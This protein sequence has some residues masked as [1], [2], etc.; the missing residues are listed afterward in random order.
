[1]TPS[2]QQPRDA[3]AD[4]LVRRLVS[5]LLAQNKDYAIVLLDAQAV[6]LAWLGSAESIFGYTSEE[7]VG[8]TSS[9]IFT[10]EDIEKHLPEYEREVAMADW[11][12]EDDRWHVRK[13]GTRIWV[14]GTMNVLRDAEGAVV[15]MVKIMRDRT[16]MRSQLDTLENRVLALQ[17]NHERTERYLNTLGHEL[18]NPVGVISNAVQW[19]AHVS[20]DD[21]LSK[22]LQVIRRQLDLLARFS[23]D[24]VDVSRLR[25]NHMELHLEPVVLQPLLQ[26]LALAMQERAQ[27][28]G[29]RLEVLQPTTPIVVTA[30]PSRLQQ[31]VLNLLDNAIKYT[32]AGG[33]IWLK[34]T[35][36]PPDAVVRVEDNGMGI[37]AEMLPRIFELFTQGPGAKEH[38]PDGLGI[39]LA[40]VRELV[41]LHQGEVQVR[42]SGPGKGSQFAVRLPL[43]P[44]RVEAG[45]H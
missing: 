13:D 6:I 31:I 36:E 22:R 30:D 39:G 43:D 4:P 11:H 9:L 23:E 8:K 24:L 7:A 14:T 29:V 16:D 26:D 28:K 40:L 45:Q 38:S 27:A 18:R 15:G 25:R 41:E 5:L 32:P 10:P 3:L 1:M 44:K 34:I 37:S 19:L 33:A 2:H 20:T 17:E 42:S 21:T 35:E 12:A